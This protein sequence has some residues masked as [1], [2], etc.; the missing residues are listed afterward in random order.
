MS[1]SGASRRTSTSASSK[2]GPSSTTTSHDF[3]PSPLDAILAEQ[4]LQ[5]YRLDPPNWRAPWD[6]DEGD[7][8]PGSTKMRGKG[9]AWPVFYPTRD[10]MD[11]DQMTES[12]VKSG[13]S[14]KL[15]I[16]ADTFSA[17][18]HILDNLKAKGML[19]NLSRIVTAV[20]QKRESQPSTFRLPSRITLTD[21]KRE[22]WF[23]DLANPAVPLS[24]LSR[25]VPHGYKGE[26]G[27]DMLAARKVEIGRA[28]WFVRAFGGIEIQSLA[29]SRLLPTAIAQYTSEFTTV[30]CEF[31]RKQLLNLSLPDSESAAPLI[32]Q[33]SRTRTTSSNASALKVSSDF[34]DP[35]ARTAWKE[36][37][38][39]TLILLNSLLSGSLLST[40]QFIRFLV[41]IIDPSA[42][43]L[44]QLSV[45][46]LLVEEYWDEVLEDEPSTARLARTCLI[47]LE[48]VEQA[49][50]LSSSPLYA[51]LENTLTSLVRSAFLALPDAFASLCPVPIFPSTSLASSPVPLL[52]VQVSEKL[53]TVLLEPKSGFITAD[54]VEQDPSVLEIIRADLSDLAH[55]R[56]EASRIPT[57]SSSAQN[58]SPSSDAESRERAQ[59]DL[60]TR[61]DNFAFPQS[62][63]SL[64]SQI[65]LPTSAQTP[66]LATSSTSPNPSLVSPSISA[67]AN[68]P[69]S[70][71]PRTRSRT[72]G[73]ILP[74]KTALP[75][76]FTWSTT[77]CRLPGTHRR[78]TV[79][80]LISIE[81][82]RERQ[83]EEKERGRQG[84]RTRS[85]RT[86]TSTSSSKGSQGVVEA[87]VKWVDDRY[88]TEG[89]EKLS[90]KT[91]GSRSDVRGLAEELMRVGA[92]S[93]GHY[94]QKMIARGETERNPVDGGE[95]S[96]HLW[97]LQTA[98]IEDANTGGKQATKGRKDDYEEL[99]KV[100]EKLSIVQLE[101][102]RIVPRWSG[103]GG[104]APEETETKVNFDTRTLLEAVSSL[105]ERGERLSV[106]RDIV[107]NGLSRVISSSATGTLAMDPESFA[108]IVNVFDLCRDYAGLLQLLVILLRQN[109]SPSLLFEIVDLVSTRLDLWSALGG[110]SELADALASTLDNSTGASRRRLLACLRPLAIAGYLKGPKQEAV[111]NASQPLVA[112]VQIVVTQA[113]A[114][115]PLVELQT[116]TVDSSPAAVSQ[117]AS[118]LHSRYGGSTNETWLGNVIDSSIQ[119]L[120]QLS[121][122]DSIVGL[123]KELDERLRGGLELPLL[124]WMRSKAPQHLIS[125]L[126]GSQ[127]TQV[128]TLLSDLV[129]EGVLPL[130]L[131]VSD[132]FLPTWRSILVLV[133]PGLAKHSAETVL[134]PLPLESTLSRTL[135]VLTEALAKAVDIPCPDASTDHPYPSP[136]SPSTLLTQQRKSVRLGCLFTST[137]LPTVSSL[138]ALL[139]LQ[140]EVST[141]AGLLDNAQ[142]ASAL[143]LRI[144]NLQQFQSLVVKIPQSVRVGMLDSEFVRSLPSFDTF[145]PKLLASLLVALKDGGDATP[146]NLVSTE[147]WDTFLSGLTLWRLAVSKVEVEACLERLELD[148]TL[149]NE[150][151][152]EALHTL[153]NHFLERV[154]TGSGQTYLGEQV[155]KCYHGAASDELVSVAFDRLASAITTLT[156][157]SETNEAHDSAMTASRCTIRLLETL[158]QSGV[159]SS[160]PSS[161][162]QVLDAIK[163]ALTEHSDKASSDSSLSTIPL[164][165]NILDIAIRCTDGPADKATADLYL[166]CLSQCASLAVSLAGAQHDT[167][168][169]STLLLDACSH[170]LLALPDL[171]PNT[172]LP[173][174]HPL[175]HSS[176]AHTGEQPP[177]FDPS[178]P[179]TTFVRLTHLFGSYTPSSSV[180]NPW[181]LLDHNE[182]S[183][184]NAT[185]ALNSSIALRNSTTAQ[186]NLRPALTNG[187]PIDL[188]AF[189]ARVIETVPA[190]TALDALSTTSSSSTTSSRPPSS[191]ASTGDPRGK[192]T[193]FDFETPCTGLSVHARDFRRTTSAARSLAMKFDQTANGSL[194]TAGGNAVAGRKRNVTGEAVIS[195]SKG[196]S[197]GTAIAE[198]SGGGGTL[199][200]STD[201][202]SSGTAPSTRGTKRK[203]TNPNT[204]VIVIDDEEEEAEVVQPTKPA[205]KTK[206]TKTVAGKGKKKK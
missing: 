188:A 105:A 116:L 41:S 166:E 19:E 115:S 54:D 21:N 45:A 10:G 145:K 78:P 186:S 36:K 138:L 189:R 142:A 198:A 86:S 103:G 180:P 69:S 162:R 139:V 2:S 155:V 167:Q 157:D 110:L 146:A 195:A 192:Q 119:L 59:L 172:P 11:E 57:T 130:P 175:L 173:S 196:A 137:S 135:V 84:V 181:E 49:S 43:T 158:L 161:L 31:V 55:R 124:R 53:E 205:K 133:L 87:F 120:A 85:T 160:R 48:Q 4:G 89:P 95:E 104:P 72:R 171:A 190:V 17:H 152:S 20:Q 100:Q 8:G 182:S 97:I 68:G 114:S 150:D 46:L 187:G 80:N 71:P 159:A 179:D 76:L 47:R 128:V 168:A 153:S 75:I 101:L 112:N 26:K 178:L 3:R 22:T 199:K 61:L 106:T 129:V 98:A 51:T 32:P 94:M 193:N 74:L 154:C 184:A 123:F 70:E 170:L 24:K 58:P 81:L 141:A 163:Q 121:S 67:T 73:P 37:F 91:I 30:V 7:D 149:T 9:K 200:A 156:T 34:T 99:R 127:G 25:S 33:H 56:L 169:T 191:L 197:S 148:S 5:R 27:L 136:L 63:A 102:A 93:Y 50:L 140:Q 38:D 18:G 6:G 107:S 165:V 143:F 108:L 122:V 13:Y 134:E 131:L 83:V 132:G 14:A 40:P 66:S 79:A 39:Y 203:A 60:I 151:K 52:P 44:A 147:D 176:S 174:I 109:P 117:L 62:I 164:L 77:P 35:K 28:V 16:A 185:N 64:H 111:L 118:L 92:L 126:G 65:F 201:S 183:S 82:E 206:A 42:T 177:S 1:R 15:P 194:A 144:V 125:I 90:G 96:I 113:L 23:S 29:K 88:S 204:E 12:A 202:T